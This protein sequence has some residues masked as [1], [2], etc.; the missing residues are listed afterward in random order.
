MLGILFGCM[1]GSW[2][3]T[4]A[5]IDWVREKFHQISEE[6]DLITI[7]ELE[8]NEGLDMQTIEAYQGV[9]MAM[10]AEHRFSPWAKYEC[11]SEGKSILEKSIS[12]G[13]NVEKIYLR[14]LLQLSTPGFLGYSENVVT[15]LQYLKANL[16]DA[17]LS[18][19][20]KRDM[21][22]TLGRINDELDEIKWLKRIYF[23]GDELQ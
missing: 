20:V 3:Q 13:L 16:P 14:L 18:E 4:I 8:P 6:K 21:V 12:A 11:F 7:I 5:D 17:E 22:L 23:E 1:V 2:Q 19:H 10:M 9:C 15:D